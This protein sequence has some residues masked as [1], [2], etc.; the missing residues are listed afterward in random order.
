MPDAPWRCSQCGTI[1]EPVANSCRTCGKWP[2]LFDLQ[3][4]VVEDAEYDL[5]QRDLGEPQAYVP[6]VYEHETIQEPTTF[7]PEAFE[8]EID[9]VSEDEPEGGRRAKWT[10]AIVP[11]ALLVYFA[12]SFFFN[13]R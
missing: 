4:S 8:P 9:T 11:L 7:E 13:D 12:I 5:P 1:N 2:S 6:D 10:S 3:D